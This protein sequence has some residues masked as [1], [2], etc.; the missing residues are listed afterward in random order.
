[1]GLLTAAAK[2]VIADGKADIRLL[3]EC[4]LAEGI[5]RL[6]TGTFPLAHEG[7]TW[8]PIV[9]GLINLTPI[10]VSEDRRANGLEISVA[11]MPLEVFSE[12]ITVASYKDRSARLI[13]GLLDTTGAEAT[14][15][16]S[17]EHRYFMDQVSFSVS[18][19]EGGTVVLKLENEFV[20]LTRTLSRRLTDQDQKSRYPADLGLE[21]VSY[22]NSGV[23]IL[24][25]E[26]G[27]FFKT[28]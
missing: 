10:A 23:S 20:H 2:T 9:N 13:M 28:E 7:E 18:P 16:Y 8:T 17:V 21:L 22:L 24:W 15:V 26:A 4:D 25:G 1:M 11:G 6:W 3:F 14:L 27:A 12:P 5:Q 19:P